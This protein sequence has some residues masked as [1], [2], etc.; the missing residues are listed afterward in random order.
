MK[1]PK[2][3]FL[4]LVILLIFTAIFQLQRSQAQAVV[5]TISGKFYRF[6]LLASNSSL[7]VAQLFNGPSINDNGVVAFTG[8]NFLYTADGINPVRNVF[9]G[10]FQNNV[11]INNNK[12]VMTYSFATPNVHFLRRFD[13]SVNPATS[14]I[15]AAINPP[16]FN[17]FATIYPS[18]SL[19]NSGQPVFSA[20]TGSNPQLITGVRPT[21]SNLTIA[22]SGSFLRPA[23]ADNGSIV[24]RAGS[25]SNAPIRLYNYALT[26]TTDIAVVSPTTFS[27][28]G[29]SPGISDNGE[30]IVFYGVAQTG[31]TIPTTPGP[32]IFA[33]IVE[34][35]TRR[36]IRIA[37]RQIENM[38]P[39]VLPVGNFD[40]IC[41]PGEQCLNGELGFSSGTTAIDFSTFNSDSR[42]GVIHQSLGMAGLADDTFIVTFLGTPNANSSAPE[43]V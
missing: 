34:G 3:A 40:G 15:V 22:G 35:T 37:G 16:T 19:N 13:T 38:R 6:D 28:L 43:V 21:F 9:S 10:P 26:T 2:L 1:N 20:L 23:I 36:T 18:S 30:V 7:G 17:D 8:T 33:S 4:I 11:H 41:D 39:T 12:L 27:S 25:N 24:A 31:N 5:T 14:T 32:G 42:I 29:Q